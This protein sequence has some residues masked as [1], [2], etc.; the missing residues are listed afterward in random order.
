M[1][2]PPDEQE[3]TQVTE[4][5]RWASDVYRRAGVAYNPDAAITR[6]WLTSARTGKYLG[7]PEGPEH[8]SE[9]GIP[10]QEFSGAVLYWKDGQVRVGL[11]F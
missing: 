1:D 10:M 7:R 2:P 8:P 5:D 3:D 11:P 9:Q 4:I 6:Y